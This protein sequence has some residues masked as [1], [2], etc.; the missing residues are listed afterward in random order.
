MHTNING[1]KWSMTH[2]V[3]KY[4]LDKLS[5]Q[6]S[7]WVHHNLWNRDCS[8][9]REHMLYYDYIY[10]Y[11]YMNV[12]IKSK[13]WWKNY[14]KNN[15]KIT[16]DKASLKLSIIF[17]NFGNFSFRQVIRISKGFDTRPSL[18]NLC[19]Y[20]CENTKKILKREIYT[21]HVFLAIC[22]AS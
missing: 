22:F 16:F 1:H 5:P 3:L 9:S 6:I 10:I 12:K 2:R 14:Y 4:H 18:A 17:F 20:Y 15:F 11:L 8:D 7:Y 13:W 21:K 19:S